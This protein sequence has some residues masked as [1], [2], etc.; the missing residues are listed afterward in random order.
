MDNY[1]KEIYTSLFKKW[2]LFH[3]YK[4]CSIKEDEENNIV[5]D[6]AD[7]NYPILIAQIILSYFLLEISVHQ[8]F[9]DYL[10]L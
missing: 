9:F 6:N 8:L 10:T 5:I 1:L 4:Y 2:I 7:N 3:Q